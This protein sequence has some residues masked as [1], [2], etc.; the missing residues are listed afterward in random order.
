MI[1]VRTAFMG[2]ESQMAGGFS[3][4]PISMSTGFA[5][6]SHSLL[7]A[8]SLPESTAV[9]GRAGW[10]LRMPRNLP[11]IQSETLLTESCIH[12]A[13]TEPRCIV[14]S[15]LATWTPG[16][17][18]LLETSG[19]WLWLTYLSE[20]CFLLSQ[21]L[22]T[23]SGL[24]HPTHFSSIRQTSTLPSSTRSTADQRSSVSTTFTKGLLGA[25]PWDRHRRHDPGQDR[26]A[27]PAA[28][29]LK[30]TVGGTVLDWLQSSS[31]QEQCDSVWP[32]TF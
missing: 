24:A 6:S 17:S 25:R 13:Q 14:L 26:L 12:D 27:P 15:A 2:E 22:W 31:A 16:A 10:R 11:F 9:P 1:I 32:R 7:P 19:H 18:C 5:P 21:E 28:F 3:P 4:R 20:G 23:S 29:V 8:L 30:Q